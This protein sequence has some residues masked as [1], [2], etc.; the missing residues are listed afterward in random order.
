MKKLLVSVLF[1][2][3]SFAQAP[4]WFGALDKDQPDY[5]IIGYGESEDIESA[6]NLA[7]DDISKSIRT[8]IKSS[9]SSRTKVNG[10]DVD[11]SIAQSIEAKNS[12]ILTNVKL[13]E[14]E[15]IKGIWY[16]SM[17]YDNRPIEQKI[18][19]SFS[20]KFC[21]ENTKTHPYIQASPLY[22]KL[23]KRV[24]CDLDISITRFNKMWQVRA[25]DNKL[26][27]MAPL[28]FEK[29][30]FNKYN[31]NLDFSANKHVL[32]NGDEF[33]FYQSSKQE[34]YTTLLTMYENGIVTVLESSALVA[35][36]KKQILPS[37]ERELE[38]EAA[39][40][41]DGSATFDLYILLYSKQPLDTSRFEYATQELASSENAY[42]F[43][44]L[45]DLM[46]NNSYATIR[47]TTNP[48]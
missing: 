26:F 21:V 36:N 3:I 33:L 15:R 12:T 38:L 37:P 7:K 18:A 10:E 9:F 22:K 46:E 48:R 34:G 14:Q 13:L 11:K 17:Q 31:S 19:N 5:M 47:L 24:G 39:T 29:L 6:K 2:S 28:D 25:L 32:K 45:L 41:E 1:I 8:A 44:E 27:P 35:K 4:F 43:D 23:K 30:F 16:V 40:L 42:K 20:K